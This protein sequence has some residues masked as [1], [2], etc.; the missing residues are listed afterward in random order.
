MSDYR[1]QHSGGRRGPRNSPVFFDD[2]VADHIEETVRLGRDLRVAARTMSDDQARYL[3]DAYYIMQE[4][5][6]RTANQER[7][8]GEEPHEVIK[9]LSEK[10]RTL[11]E[12]IKV[13]L[14]NYT[15]GHKMGPWMRR[16]YGIGPVL[17]AGLLAHIYMGIWCEHCRGHS[18]KDCKERQKKERAR[19]RTKAK[20]PKLKVPKH[21]YSPVES[22]PT[23]GHI[24][25]YAG[26][27]ADGQKPWE[28]GKKRPFNAEFKTLCWKVGQS[29]MK[30][31]NEDD[32][33]YGKYYRER[34]AYE[35]R[36][37]EAGKLAD[38]A[39]A[40]LPR[41]SPTTESYKHYS[42]GRLPPAHIDERARRYAVKMFLSHLHKVWYEMEFGRPAPFP[43]PIEHLGHAHYIPPPAA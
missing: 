29:F 19:L 33:V 17:S 10:N 13:A 41:F 22:C 36:N 32:C 20:N 43:F 8:L 34:K 5:R 2:D 1:G 11:E 37:N 25:Q 28:K 39:A 27:A 30:F 9:W 12:Q 16:V 26:Y 38:Q 3:V 23:V 15:Q 21:K 7:S 42:E 35:I 14:D 18:K 6:K 24:W 31:S 4:D 40:M